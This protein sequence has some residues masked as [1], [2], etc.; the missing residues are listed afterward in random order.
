MKIANVLIRAVLLASLPGA[1][2]AQTPAAE[3]H[4]AM[5]DF[6]VAIRQAAAGLETDDSEK[7]LY[8]ARAL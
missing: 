4:P 2:Q 6:A 1:V 3:T 5:A 8:A 7:L